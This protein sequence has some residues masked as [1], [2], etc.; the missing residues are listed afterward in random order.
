MGSQ[1]IS[2]QRRMGEILIQKDDGQQFLHGSVQV[3]EGVPTD[4]I[5]QQLERR[6]E[7]YLDYFVFEEPSPDPD[8]PERNVVF[9]VATDA[10]K[11]DR[12]KEEKSLVHLFAPN[13]LGTLALLPGARYVGMVDRTWSDPV[14]FVDA[15]ALIPQGQELSPAQKK[16]ADSFADR[17]KDKIGG[18]RPGVAEI[19]QAVLEVMDDMR[20]LCMGVAKTSID[21]VDDPEGKPGAKAIKVSVE[22]YPAA[23]R[24]TIEGIPEAVRKSVLAAIDEEM[25]AVLQDHPLVSSRK[26]GD[27]DGTGP[28]FQLVRTNE[29]GVISWRFPPNIPKP[30][31]K[32]G[33]AIIGFF[34][35]K[36]PGRVADTLP[37]RPMPL[38]MSVFEKLIKRLN[39]R[40]GSEPGLY[41]LAWETDID[42]T[43]RIKALHRD[44]PNYVLWDDAVADLKATYGIDLSEEQKM[45]EGGTSRWSSRQATEFTERLQKKFLAAGRELLID[46]AQF[47]TPLPGG[48]VEIRFFHI[49]LIKPGKVRFSGDVDLKGVG[50]A[51][52][53]TALLGTK[54]MTRAELRERLLK[55]EEHYHKAG[56]LL[57]GENPLKQEGLQLTPVPKGKDGSMEVIVRVA[58][59]GKV[60]VS[61]PLPQASKDALAKALQSPEGEPLRPKK[62]LGNARRALIRLELLEKDPP[63][64][65]T[66]P[67]GVMD[68]LVSA[69]SPHDNYLVGIG[70]DGHAFLASGAA[71]LNHVVPGTTHLG[72]NF[73]VGRGVYGGDIFVKTLP[74]NDDG[75]FLEAS[76][77]YLYGRYWYRESPA[78]LEESGT[79]HRG[80][81]SIAVHVPLGGQGIAS[82]FDLFVGTHGAVVHRDGQKPDGQ[83]VRKTS[84]YVGNEVGVSSIHDS[85]LVDG[86]LLKTRVSVGLDHNL[87]DHSGDTTVAGSISYAIPLGKYFTLEASASAAARFA[88]YGGD[89]PPERYFGEGSIPLIDFGRSFGDPYGASYFWH[90][91]LFVV[92]TN[93]RYIQPMVGTTVSSNGRGGAHGGAGVAVRIPLVGL[94]IYLGCDQSGRLTWGLGAGGAWEL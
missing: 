89:L 43:V 10:S 21:I 56:Y 45:L 20:E 27:I 74:L 13:D 77:G 40:L 87:T 36:S 90:S 47:L 94:S 3:F 1:G 30:G 29:S 65:V 2:G 86:D 18:R 46:H 24:I 26:R 84:Y 63:V 4:Q 82:P 75:V 6:P 55:I 31:T 80:R 66:R 28:T 14:R 88:A 50:G 35:G 92:L 15:R 85:V 22:L 12:P 41:E 39:E 32:V 19:H 81:G 49:E 33:D 61:D 42:G 58:R 72:V 62:L 73:T 7:Q 17:L 11:Y 48:K 78:S 60:R 67:D 34:E 8:H 54:P 57:T 69:K 76:V 9:V 59:M 93:N 44:R 64:F 52:A 79:F 38:P 68:M 25:N 23:E 37:G 53:L 5:L 51:A 71:L 16:L 70:T 83:K 91:G